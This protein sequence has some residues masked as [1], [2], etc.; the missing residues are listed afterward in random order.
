M[1]LIGLLAAFMLAVSLPGCGTLSKSATTG[2]KA[3]EEAQSERFKR[4][5]I[6]R[7]RAK[8][9]AVDHAKRLVTI[10][11]PLGNTVV[12]KVD[13]TV[14]NLPQVKVGDSVLVE[15]EESVAVRVMKPGED[16]GPAKVEASLAAAKPGEKL[17]GVLKNQI[18]TTATI[19]AIDKTKPSVVL[20]G[21]QG[22][23]S[24]VKVLYPENLD[25][26]KVGDQIEI[27]Y[28]EALAIS[29]EEIKE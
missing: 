2:E 16:A 29:V 6:V 17:A 11:G 20:K 10:T 23:L 9:E 14:R 13:E 24:E 4:G 12:M 26:V 15:Y 27:T 21:R 7:A 1:K 22:E 8:V 18:T 25:R 28:T 3:A 5:D 19:E